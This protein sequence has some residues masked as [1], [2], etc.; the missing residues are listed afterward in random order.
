MLHHMR[1]S[2]REIT[3]PAKI[4]EILRNGRYVAIALADG[5][6]PYVVTL[7]Y[8]YDSTAARLYFHAAHEGRKLDVI[9]RNP[10]ACATVVLD[11]GYTVGECE[12]PFRSVV[13]AGTMRVVEDADEKL[14]AIHTL[15]AH[16][17]PDAAGYWESRPWALEQRLGGFA[18]LA[19]D[20]ETRSA[21]T[22]K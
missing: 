13:L 21:K 5:D 10:R 22:G 16:L 2:D 17:E 3:E 8:G 9:A 4:D 12:H 19:F 15:V 18:V 1:R 6:K 20:I 7:S 11:D 14:H